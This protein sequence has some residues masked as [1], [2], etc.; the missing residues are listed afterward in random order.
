MEPEYDFLKYWRIVR[1]WARA[2]Y[3]IGTAEMD[4]MF[5]LYSEERFT[6]KQ[7][8]QFE[9]IMSY[10]PYRFNNLL[11]DGFIVMWRKGKT[12][13]RN[14]YTLSNRSKLMISTIYRKLMQLGSISE[15]Y[16]YNPIFDEMVGNNNDKRY[17]RAIKKFNEQI[18]S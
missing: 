3:E 15:N 1:Y 7:V 18:N 13:N 10:N 16:H 8:V 14:L 9:S 11:D 4:L 17:R 6:K 5:Y 2:K 12:K